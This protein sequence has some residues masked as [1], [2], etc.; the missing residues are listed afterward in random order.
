MRKKVKVLFGLMLIMATLAPFKSKVYGQDP[1]SPTFMMDYTRQMNQIMEQGMKMLEDY[2]NQIRSCSISVVPGDDDTFWL[3]IIPVAVRSTDLKMF[4]ERDGDVLRCDISD[5]AMFGGHIFTGSTFLP[6]DVVTIIYGD[7]RTVASIPDKSNPTAYYNY[8]TKRL[9]AYCNYINMMN[10]QA[11]NGYNS[12]S[13]RPSVS[14]IDERCSLCGGAGNAD[15]PACRGRGTIPHIR[16]YD[17]V[18]D[19]RNYY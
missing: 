15:C 3:H 8:R 5:Y 7:K 16:P 17:G 9:Q 4:L 12:G 1:L 18:H 13:Y 11:G 10:Q 2:N 6:G 19:P 14:I